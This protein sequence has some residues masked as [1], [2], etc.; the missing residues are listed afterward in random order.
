[1]ETTTNWGEL[2]NT[3]ICE[4]DDGQPLDCDGM[5]WDDGLDEL[6]YSGIIPTFGEHPFPAT[7]EVKG[8]PLWGRT[9]S[10]RF[11]AK[12][13]VDFVEGISVNSMWKMRWESGDGVLTVKLWHHDVPTG[14]SFT[15]TLVDYEDEN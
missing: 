2:S 1:M 5:C 3:C 14:G 6:M 10:G 8:L 11:T 4:T 9:V 7:Y 15:V 13:L 12:R